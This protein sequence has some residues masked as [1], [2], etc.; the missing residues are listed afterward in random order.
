MLEIDLIAIASGDPRHLTDE[1]RAAIAASEVILLPCKGCDKSD[2]AR[3]REALV[4]RFAPKGVRVARFD[5]PERDP[6]L[7]YLQAVDAWHDEIALR[8]MAAITE[9]RDTRRVALLVW[10]D[11]SLYDSTLRIAERLRPRPIVR[12]IPGLTSLQLLTAAHRIPLNTL[13]GE[14]L[15]TTGRQLKAQGWPDRVD[16]LAVML[17]GACAFRSLDPAGFHIWW[18]AYL[19]MQYQTLLQGPLDEV[20]DEIVGTRDRLRAR[21]G[22]IM[23]IYLLRRMAR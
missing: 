6:S 2:L 23:D 9:E 17:D 5:M 11:P 4:D 21:H 19:G 8:W 20:G 3:V 16:S 10:G 1:A 7:P 12:V 22:W 18:G 14:V 15:V 13:G